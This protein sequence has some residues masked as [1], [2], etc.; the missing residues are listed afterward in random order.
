[1]YIRFF[2]ILIAII[3]GSLAIGGAFFGFLIGVTWATAGIITLWIIIVT[4]NL[5][6]VVVDS[7]IL[8]GTLWKALMV[9]DAVELGIV[10]VGLLLFQN[11]FRL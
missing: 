11:H 3:M 2:I 9:F 4:S 10:S 1:M 7:V 5:M 8:F 6:N